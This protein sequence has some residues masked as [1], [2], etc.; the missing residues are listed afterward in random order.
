[1]ASAGTL[2]KRGLTA[3][4]GHFQVEVVEDGGYAFHV[5]NRDPTRGYRYVVGFNELGEEGD[6]L[7][8]EGDE[9]DDELD[10]EVL[11]DASTS[12]L[13]WVA[14]DGTVTE[15]FAADVGVRDI[16]VTFYHDPD[17]TTIGFR[18]GPDGRFAVEGGV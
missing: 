10:E 13:M 11:L 12:P 15:T 2:K 9:E 1:M 5:V 8:E 4:K 14:A 7:G 17:D 6:E 18:R 3:C 16:R